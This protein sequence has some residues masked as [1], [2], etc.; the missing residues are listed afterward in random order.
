[1]VLENGTR[2]GRYQILALLGSGGMG[3]VYRARDVELEREVAVK[4]LPGGLAETAQRVERFKRE[5][6]ALA[7]L[8]HPNILEVFDIGHEDRQVFVV[9][10]LLDGQTLRRCL[11]DTGLGWRKAVEIAAAVAEGLAAAH[12]QGVIHRDLKPENVI[13]TADGRVKILDF[14][15]ARVFRPVS[16]EAETCTFTAVHTEPGT[17]MGTV[18]Y[19]SPE[20]VRG[21][22]VDQRSDLFS[23]GCLLYEMVTGRRAFSG[24][25]A[26]ETSAAILKEEPTEMSGLAAETPAELQR[27][28]ARCLEKQRDERF[29]SAR[30]LAFAL[31][32]LLTSTDALDGRSAAEAEDRPSVAVLPFDNLSTDPEQEYFCDGMAEEIINALAHLES[33]RVVA[34]TSSF[35]FKGRHEDIREIGQRL[36]V[37]NLLE[38][39]VRKADD[40]LRI[41]AQLID[42]RSGYHLWSERYDRQ[43]EDVF[44]IQDEIALA[45]VDRLKVR[46]LGDELAAIVKRPTEDLDAYNS[47]LQGLFH[48]GKLTP[49][50]YEDSRRCYEEAIRIDPGFASPYSGLAVWYLSQSFWGTLAPREGLPQA[51]ALAEKALAL[52][53]NESS[54]HN[55]I[56]CILAFLE[57]DLAAGERRLQRAIELGPN[58]AV[59]HLN[60]GILLAS[61]ER[62][63]EAVLLLRRA[64]ALD[65]LAVTTN[66]WAGRVMALAGLI[67][68][69]KADIERAMALDRNHW[70]PHFELA[71][72]YAAESR[73]EEAR[74]EAEKAVELS[75]GEVPVALQCLACICYQQGD[76]GRGDEFLERVRKRARQSYVPSM[77][78]VSMALARGDI[79]EA[80]RRLEDAVATKDPWVV[81]HDYVFPTPGLREARI[82]DAFERLGL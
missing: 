71:E 63:D 78:F 5:A 44:A 42:V 49:A 8:S 27:L 6:K 68:E 67:E 76:A 52:D 15:L 54:A 35:A 26:A 48:W 38:G 1:M 22:V 46:L 23:L 58:V 14:G 39:S 10:E 12:A 62:F 29:Q 17:V 41:T 65:P 40:R 43:L 3:E 53:E 80:L 30:D 69:G 31:R 28:V 60:L 36:Q 59:N 37:Q 32:S 21:E 19:M 57:R 2:L 47:Y 64:Q 25:S 18:G 45:I 34:R 9:M 70:L 4:V 79:D 51:R 16:A 56:G 75:A 11:E 77:F 50:G 33:L 61:R 20:Q 82:D 73:L 72:V 66:T 7:R 55:I 13:L 81:L 24:K 74:A